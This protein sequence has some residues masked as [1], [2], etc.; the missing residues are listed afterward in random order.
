M[1]RAAVLAGGLVL[2]GVLLSPTAGAEGCALL[3]TCPEPEPDAPPPPPTT[4]TTTVRPMTSAEAAARLVALLNDER[5][6]SGLVPFTVRADVTEIAVGWSSAMARAEHLSHNDAYFTKDTRL[7]LDAR[8]LGENVARNGSVDGAHRALMESPPHRANILDARFTVIGVAAELRDGSWWVTQDFVQPASAGSPSRPVATAE[9]PATAPEPSPS[10]AAS[11]PAAPV[12][13][14]EPAALDDDG[15][16]LS[17][18]SAA[19]AVESMIAR[20]LPVARETSAPA[21]P[22]NAPTP[23]AA[24]LAAVALLVAYLLSWASASARIRWR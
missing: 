20:R 6:A 11:A 1:L 23:W 19:P 16:V 18:S 8:M 7:R 3:L 21:T 14:P 13:A 22:G 2:G 10:T 17:A 15:E 4:T 24:A 12:A 9:T 5:A